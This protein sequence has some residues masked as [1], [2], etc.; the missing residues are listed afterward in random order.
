MVIGIIL[1]MFVTISVISILGLLVMFL[2][3]NPRV[4][5]GICYAMAIWG[6]VLAVLA[7]TSLPQNFIAGQMVAWGAGGLGAAGLLLQV[8]AKTSNQ[9][10]ASYL[11]VTASIIV[12]ILKLFAIV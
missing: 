11:L 5:K 7:A 8:V 10:M 6:M 3:K 4:K 12:G 2:S 1:I 9:R